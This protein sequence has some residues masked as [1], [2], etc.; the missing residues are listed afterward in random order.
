VTIY[1]AHRWR[2]NA[3][4]VA[5]IAELYLD[6]RM[7]TVDVTYG[8]GAWWN[9][10]RPGELVPHGLDLDG[11]GHLDDGVD[12]TALPEADGTYDL[13]AFDPPYVS[14]GGRETQGAA[15]EELARRFGMG[16][17]SPSPAANQDLVNAGLAELYRVLKP[18]TRR[19]EPV[20]GLAIVKVQD[21]VSSGRLFDGVYRTTTAA[22][23]L[24]FLVLDRFELLTSG[25][26]QPT[27]NRDGTPRRQVHAR[28]NHSTML[29]LLKAPRRRV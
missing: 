11:R 2:T 26:P 4:L 14:T 23:D 20:T 15:G 16:T 10:W 19:N 7:V 18:S 24:G 22:L 28:R 1:A 3:E 21:Y 27:A 9:A 5:D 25:G 29:V 8:L 6:R 17:S 13:A 12:F